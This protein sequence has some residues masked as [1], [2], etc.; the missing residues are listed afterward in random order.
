MGGAAIA[1]LAVIVVAPAL[2]G[3]GRRQRT[4]VKP[5]SGQRGDTTV[6]ALHRHQRG[7][8]G[9]AAIAQLAVSVVAPAL[10]G[11]GR[12]QRAC[13]KPASGQRGDTTA[14]A[15]HRHRRGAAGGA[16]IAQLAVSI[17]A[18]ALDG[19]GRRQRARVRLARNYLLHPFSQQAG[20]QR[21]CG[22]RLSLGSQA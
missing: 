6:Q 15:R 5:I 2:D 16:A 13:V 3:P 7:A 20:G 10:D 19:P 11:P 14:Q 8:V 9:G 21:R 1:Q 12:R 22:R 4:R 18:P 17:V